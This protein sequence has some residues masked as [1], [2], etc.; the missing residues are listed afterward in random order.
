MVTYG[1]LLAITYTYLAVFP[2]KVKWFLLGGVFISTAL[3]P[4][5]LVFL[6]I[7]S[8]RASDLELTNRKERLVPYLVFICS[9]LIC[10]FFMYRIN[11]P[12]WLKD[13]ILGVCFALFLAMCINFV[14]KISAHAIGIGG[15]L[16]GVMGVCKMY[17]MNPYWL[18]IIILMSVGLLGTSRVI[19][20]NIH[21]CRFMPDFVLVLPALSYFR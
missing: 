13:M 21:R 14:W 5:L 8:G 3:V 17:M 4:G 16:G 6:Y 10:L 11:A 18:F 19:L 1:V 20:K 15:L 12:F 9:D 7:K 2:D